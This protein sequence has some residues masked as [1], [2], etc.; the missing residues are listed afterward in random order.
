MYKALGIPDDKIYTYVL[1]I[2][3]AARN[4]LVDYFKRQSTSKNHLYNCIVNLKQMIDWVYQ[5]YLNNINSIIIGD[6]NDVHGHN[7]YISGDN[8]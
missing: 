5:N 3:M 7:I 2:H 6:N 1:P 8:N 4:A